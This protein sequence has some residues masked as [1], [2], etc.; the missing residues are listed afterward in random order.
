MASD[1]GFQMVANQTS[2]V[3]CGLRISEGECGD[4]GCRIERTASLDCAEYG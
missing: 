3:G 2:T 1:W 4:A